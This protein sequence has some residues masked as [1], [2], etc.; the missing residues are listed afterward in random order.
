MGEGHTEHF[1]GP[2][3]GAPGRMS[4]YSEIESIVLCLAVG[5]ELLAGRTAHACSIIRLFQYRKLHQ[6][7]ISD[8]SSNDVPFY[9][10]TD[11]FWGTCENNVSRVECHDR[12]DV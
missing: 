7:V 4:L 2:C 12:A 5:C 1:R 6:L 11:S 10:W 9:D 8:T 3:D